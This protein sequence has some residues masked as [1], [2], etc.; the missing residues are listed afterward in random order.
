MPIYD[1]TLNYHDLYTQI[2]QRNEILLKDY[3]GILSERAR[4]YTLYTNMMNGDY[5]HMEDELSK[6][7]ILAH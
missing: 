7:K 3:E 5:S 4:M 1:P 2:F 6:E